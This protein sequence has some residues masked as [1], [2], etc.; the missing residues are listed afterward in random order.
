M[1]PAAPAG[2]ITAITCPSPAEAMSVDGSDVLISFGVP[3]T[4]NGLAPVT[5]SCSLTSGDRFAVGST[6]VSPWARDSGGQS[7]ACSFT[8]AFSA[9]AADD[10]FVAF[11]DGLTEKWSRSPWCYPSVPASYLAAL[12]GLL[13]AVLA[14]QTITV[15]NAGSAGEFTSADGLKRFGPTPLAANTPRSG[16]C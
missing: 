2:G 4:A 11:G 9:A 15:V 13:R 16:A 7:A 3:T 6:T 10:Q 14:S 5:S 1:A 12:R 8:V